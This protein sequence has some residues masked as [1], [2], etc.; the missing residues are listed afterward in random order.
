MPPEHT[1]Q[2]FGI[3]TREPIDEPQ[4]PPVEK[5]SEKNTAMQEKVGEGN[6]SM[7]VSIYG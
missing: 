6:S 3:T 5:G 2:T 1:Q 7:Y 4:P